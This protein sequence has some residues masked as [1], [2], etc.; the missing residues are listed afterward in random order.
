ML[1]L[2]LGSLFHFLGLIT[3]LRGNFYYFY[4]DIEYDF[5][6]YN[7]LED[8]T[9]IYKNLSFNIENIHQEENVITYEAKQ[10]NFK[11]VLYYRRL[12][13]NMEK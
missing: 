7:I 12:Y 1:I 3:S 10:L 2:L 13:S 5:E 11:T 8:G 9:M 4:Q 6:F